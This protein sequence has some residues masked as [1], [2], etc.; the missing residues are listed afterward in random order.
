VKERKAY[1]FDMER[2][3]AV[4]RRIAEYADGN[5]MEQKG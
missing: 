3:D 2:F 1:R 5:G 4:K